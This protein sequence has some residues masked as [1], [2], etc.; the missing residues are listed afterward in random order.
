MN[1]VIIHGS[2]KKN[3]SLLSS[4]QA[5]LREFKLE[6]QLS[7]ESTIVI[8]F[9]ANDLQLALSSNTDPDGV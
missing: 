6:G 5:K 9:A 2:E 7:L 3:H 4:S 8:D 1:D